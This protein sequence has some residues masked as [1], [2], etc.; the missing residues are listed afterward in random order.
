[1]KFLQDIYPHCKG[2]GYCCWKAK[3]WNALREHGYGDEVCPS[4]KWDGERHVCALM[5]LPGDEGEAYRK[6]LFAGEGCCSPNN[7]WRREPLKDRTH[8]EYEK[9]ETV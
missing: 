8:Y 9:D 2:C 7:S 6:D 4:L 1:M 3:C 5:G